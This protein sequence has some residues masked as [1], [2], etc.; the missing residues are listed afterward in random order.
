MQVF[1]SELARL[2]YI[3]VINHLIENW[4]LQTKNNFIK[5]F[6]LKIQ[7]IKLH[8]NS[9]LE[10]LEYKGL[11]KCLVTKQTTFYYRVLKNQQEIEIIT[12][13]DTRQN[14]NKLNKDL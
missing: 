6:D 2:K 11:Y 10:S 1:Y 13:F 4:S 7:Q 3:K 14:P 8:P 9:C 5:K 12:V